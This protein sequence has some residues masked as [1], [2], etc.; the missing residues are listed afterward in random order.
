MGPL[1][2]E[3]GEPGFSAE[4]IQEQRQ[5]AWPRELEGEGQDQPCGQ[6]TDE[7]EGPWHRPGILRSL[8]RK[9][10]HVGGGIQDKQGDRNQ[11]LRAVCKLGL[12]F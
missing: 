7:A 9:S 2:S 8:T 12:A 4:D 1:A 6:K 10:M 3:P 11:A 5:V